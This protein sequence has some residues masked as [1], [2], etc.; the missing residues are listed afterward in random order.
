MDGLALGQEGEVATLGP[1]TEDFGE[2]TDMPGYNRQDLVDIC[3]FLN[4]E[5]IS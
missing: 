5:E 4:T 1:C 3:S 2:V